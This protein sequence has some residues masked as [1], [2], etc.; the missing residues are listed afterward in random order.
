MFSSSRISP[1]FLSRAALRFYLLNAFG[2]LMAAALL[3]PT[4]VSAAPNPPAPCPAIAHPHVDPHRRLPDS[5]KVKIPTDRHAEFGADSGG[6]SLGHQARNCAQ[7][8]MSRWH[9]DGRTHG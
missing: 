2:L 9:I 8:A 3:F 5:F 4:P 6:D 7:K 1:K